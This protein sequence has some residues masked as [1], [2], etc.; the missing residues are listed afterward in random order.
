MTRIHGKLW[1]A[2]RLSVWNKALTH[3]PVFL[4]QGVTFQTACFKDAK[5]TSM[6]NEA[7]SSDLLMSGATSAAHHWTVNE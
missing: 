3:V 4:V 6:K 2:V 5:D 7:S 1:R